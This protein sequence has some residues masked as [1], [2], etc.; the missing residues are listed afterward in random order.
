MALEHRQIL[1][2]GDGGNLHSLQSHFKKAAGG[3][4]AQVVEMQIFLV[5]P[6]LTW[7]SQLGAKKMRKI[8][9]CIGAPSACANFRDPTGVSRFNSQNPEAIFTISLPPEAHYMADSAG[10][11]CVADNYLLS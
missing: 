9:V 11:P 1:V 6:A 2:A 5:G 10:W 4:V 7:K 8:L 3:L